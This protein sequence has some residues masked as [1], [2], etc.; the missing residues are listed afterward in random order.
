MK[1]FYVLVIISFIGFGIA[2]SYVYISDKT[3]QGNTKPIPRIH[4]PFNSFVAATGIVESKSKN[5]IIGSLMSG[6]IKQIYIHNAQKIKKGNLLFTLDDSVIQNKIA[7]LKVQKSILVAKMQATKNQFELIKEF[8]HLSYHMITSAKFQSKQDNYKI[9]Q[10]T[11]KALDKKLKILKQNK[12]FYKVYAPID[13]VVL[14]SKLTI[15]EYFDKNDFG[16]LLIIGSDKLNLNVSVNEYDIWKFEKKSPAIAF[17]RG[18]PKLKINL[19]YL[20]V[21]PYVVPK[22]TLIGRSTERTDTKVLHVVYEL[23]KKV[24]FP[25]YVGQQ[26]DVFIKTDR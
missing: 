26:L 4:L 6:I 13:G 15:G 10:V 12:E 25:L 14:S 5:I 19:K 8:Q 22:I 23:P 17:V 11:L 18:H 2:L 1:N 20:Y 7:M 16:N 21:I 3:K 9:A 24:S